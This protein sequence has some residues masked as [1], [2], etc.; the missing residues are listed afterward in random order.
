MRGL[1]LLHRSVATCVASKLGPSNTLP[2]DLSPITAF[3]GEPCPGR[4]CPKTQLQVHPPQRTAQ[5]Q[6]ALPAR[7]VGPVQSVRRLPA[8]LVVTL[9]KDKGSSK[10]SNLPPG[11]ISMSASLSDITAFSGQGFLMEASA[12]LDGE[13]SHAALYL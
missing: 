3:A 13:A 8:G 12:M 7:C 9:L 6:Y 1:H 4:V 2:E 11:H 10:R 5:F